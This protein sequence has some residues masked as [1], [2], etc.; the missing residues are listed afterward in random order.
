MGGA[1]VG[2]LGKEPSW[3]VGARL[4]VG[5][6]RLVIGAIVVGAIVVGAVEAG[7]EAATPGRPSPD[8]HPAS[9]VSAADRVSAASRVRAANGTRP[10]A[11]GDANKSWTGRLPRAADIS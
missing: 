4:G 9:K 6:A 3:D 11:T 5:P 8:P 2:A 1:D 10:A 7:I